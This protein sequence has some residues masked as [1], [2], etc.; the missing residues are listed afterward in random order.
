MVLHKGR[1]FASRWAHYESAQPGSFRLVPPVQRHGALAQD[2]ARMQPMFLVPP[3]AFDKMMEQLAR[4]EHH[5][6]AGS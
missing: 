5:L 4:A 2:Y 6:N 1:Y 3:P